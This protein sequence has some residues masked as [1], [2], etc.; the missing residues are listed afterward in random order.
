M[1]I[2]VIGGTGFIGPHLVRQLALM[3]HSVDVSH[4]GGT[5]ADFPAG[6]IP[7]DRRDLA[8]LR[9]QAFRGVAHRVVV[10][11]AIL[12]D[13]D[14]PGTVLRLPMI[15]GP[16][17][18]LG[19]FYPVLQRIDHGRR[20]ILLEESWAAS[21][22]LREYV[23]NV[24]AALVLSAVSERAAAADDAHSVGEKRAQVDP[25]GPGGLQHKLC[26]IPQGASSE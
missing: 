18:R 19:R 13:P 25:R 1:R 11:R 6:H 8:A 16:G 12:G 17:D 7:G 22:S 5:Q 3:G 20:V 24:A 15:Y 4:R 14:L 10:E 21:R 2:L 23:E 9:P 26:R